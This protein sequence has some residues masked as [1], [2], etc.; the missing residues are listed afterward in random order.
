MIADVVQKAHT[1]NASLPGRNVRR[2]FVSIFLKTIVMCLRATQT[3]DFSVAV[4]S[5]WFSTPAINLFV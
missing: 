4:P 3:N 2:I 1:E 5:M